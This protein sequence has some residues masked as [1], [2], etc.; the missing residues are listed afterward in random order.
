MLVPRHQ[1]PATDQK[2]VFLFSLL[3]DISN[4]KVKN[5]TSPKGDLSAATSQ[6]VS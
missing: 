6:G 2:H 4:K 3:L 5:V 1:S